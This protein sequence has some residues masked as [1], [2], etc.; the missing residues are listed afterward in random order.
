MC[1]SVTDVKAKIDEVPL[2]VDEMPKRN[3][4]EKLRHCMV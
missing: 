3:A 1:I 4:G 2:W